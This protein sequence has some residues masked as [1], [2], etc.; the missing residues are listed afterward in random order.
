MLFVAFKDP[1]YH[2]LDN[3]TAFP[4][5]ILKISYGSFNEKVHLE[6]KKLY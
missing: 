2:G 4:M 5:S 6:N 3:I 1:I